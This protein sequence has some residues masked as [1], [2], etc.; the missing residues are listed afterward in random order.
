MTLVLRIIQ[1]SVSGRTHPH[2]RG[3]VCSKRTYRLSEGTGSSH[4]SAALGVELKCALTEAY[5]VAEKA[6]H[7]QGGVGHSVNLPLMT[8]SVRARGE[9]LL[10]GAA[11]ILSSRG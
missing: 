10:A 5:L 8:N 4:A 2:E 9:R 1:D 7:L 3:G 11:R 6:I